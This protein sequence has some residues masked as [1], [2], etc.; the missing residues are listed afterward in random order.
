MI[1]G[2]KSP[3]VNRVR[4]PLLPRDVI[5]R[6]SVC[7]QG[8]EA[9]RDVRRDSRSGSRPS[10]GNRKRPPSPRTRAWAQIACNSYSKTLIRFVSK[11]PPPCTAPQS[12]LLL[13]AQR[14]S[15]RTFARGNCC[16]DLIVGYC[17]RAFRATLRSVPWRLY[18]GAPSI[19]PTI[20]HD[21][22]AD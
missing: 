4:A 21:P 18:P 12:L 2:R 3:P 11:G 10:F 7:G 6:I 19:L 15:C 5:I 16:Q 20:W 9:E 13:F 1:P 17:P 22:A 14:L 8:S